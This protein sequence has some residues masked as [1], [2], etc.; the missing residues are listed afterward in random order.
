[1]VG[2]YAVGSQSFGARPARDVRRLFFDISLGDAAAGQ[3][4][5]RYR[6]RQWALGI[7]GC[8]A[9]RPPAR[10]RRCR[11]GARCRAQQSRGSPQCQLASGLRVGLAVRRR[12][13]RFRLFARRA[14]SR[15]RHRAGAPRHRGKTQARCAV[16]GL[17]LLCVRQSLGVL[18]HALENFERRT[19]DFVARAL[20]GSD[21]GDDRHR[22]SGLL[23]D[24]AHGRLARQDRNA[25][26]LMAADLLPPPVVLCDAHRRLRPV[27]HAAGAAVYARANASHVGGRR[28]R[29]DQILPKTNRI[30]SRSRKNH[31]LFLRSIYRARRDPNRS[32]TCRVRLR[33]FAAPFRI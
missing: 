10:A 12:R 28:F 33:S 9:R 30:G 5:R 2:L 11:R 14:A 1:M 13:A 31:E 20:S 7:A 17:S 26:A 3:H 8:A 21:R 23:A 6:L 4:R 29:T 16:S 24:R 22:L 27:L 19:V 32:T 15:S 25:A 18:P